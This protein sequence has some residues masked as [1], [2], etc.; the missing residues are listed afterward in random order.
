[1]VLNSDKSM[2]MYYRDNI[3]IDHSCLY[4][5]FVNDYYRFIITRWRLS[6]HSLLIET[7]RHKRPIIPREERKCELCDVLHDEKNAIFECIRYI[8]LR[9]RYD[10]LINVNYSVKM[11]LNPKP[12]EIKDTAIYLHEIG[13][14]RI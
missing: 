1:M 12:N 11:F 10:F 13:R 4:N 9:Q 6:N 7:G 2:V 5:S 8:Y 14:P 3:F